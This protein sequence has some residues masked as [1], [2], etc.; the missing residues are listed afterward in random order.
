MTKNTAKALS[1]E[2]DPPPVLPIAGAAGGYPVNR[3]FCVGRN[4]ADHAKE[5]GFEV[6]REAPW[7]FTK[8]A[9]AI[10]LSG[11]TIPYPPETKNYHYE[12]ELVVA[13]GADAFRIGRERR[14]A[15]HIWLRVRPR[16]DPERFADCRLRKIAALGSRQSLRTIRGY[17]SYHTGGELSRH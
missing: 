2:L 14:A 4:Y 3:I 6:D 12:M 8:P 16:H 1:F 15:R 11:A 13:I 5:M 10:V 7:Y 9:S 17:F